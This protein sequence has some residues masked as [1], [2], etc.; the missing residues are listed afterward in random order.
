MVF[1]AG[2]DCFQNV[3]LDCF[4]WNEVSIM[5]AESETR[6]VDRINFTISYVDILVQFIHEPKI[7]HLCGMK[8]KRRT[9]ILC[10]DL[11]V[12]GKFFCR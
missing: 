1:P 2:F 5:N 11:E 7:D 4:A 3:L 6:L 9:R 8:Q 10:Q 12:P